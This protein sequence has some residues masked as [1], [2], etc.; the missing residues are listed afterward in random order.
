MKKNV[1]F[2]LPLVL[3]SLVA[4]L[5]SGWVRIGWYGLSQPS[6]NG[7]H[8]AIMVGS[9]IGTLICLERTVVL[10]N[11]WIYLLP[12]LS[13]ISIFLFFGG[14]PQLAYTSLTI[15][16]AGLIGVFIYL[17]NKHKEDYMVV[18]LIGAVAWLVGNVL[19]LVHNFYPVAVNWWIGFLLL[20][21]AGERIE[22]TKFLPNRKTKSIYLMV[23]LGIFM[24]GILLPYHSMGRF[25]AAIG[26]IATGAGLSFFDMARKNI[27]KEG[28]GRFTAA[29]LLAGYLWLIATGIFFVIGNDHAFGY[30]A[31]LHAF[32]VGFVFSMI[33]AHGPIILPGVIGLPFKPYHKILYVWL[34]VLHLS[35]I[36]RLVADFSIFVVLRKWSGMINGITILCFFVTL[37]VLVNI[38]KDKYNKIKQKY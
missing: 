38:E 5:W 1:L 3:I 30:D 9:F 33:F 32:F 17:Y 23:A 16:S 20:T 15:A 14:L 19:M 2:V 26:L 36:V 6:I 31:A 24:L 4:G 18:M 7:E 22:L 10:K 27:K 29:G 28:L 35:L 34:A 25:V 21:I 12:I 37:A 13:G 8:G 11:K